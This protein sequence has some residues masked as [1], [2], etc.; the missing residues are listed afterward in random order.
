MK[1]GSFLV[2]LALAVA[3]A[4]AAEPPDAAYKQSADGVEYP[5]FDAAHRATFALG[6]NY[7]FYSAEGAEPAPPFDKEFSLGAYGAWNLVP[8]L[9]AVGS[10]A[11]GVDNQ[12][13]RT[14]L[15]V[16][17]TA[18]PAPVA[19]GLGMQYEWFGKAGDT[20]PPVPDKEFAIGARAGYP[21]N[22]WLVAVGSSFYG[23]DTKQIRSSLGLRAVL[24]SP[25][26]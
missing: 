3:P 1:K 13:V 9:S 4:F 26:I 14:A 10:V 7:E 6:G 11:Y 22:H 2:L 16:S 12:F 20:L 5:I 19:V 15:G 17:Y 24:F 21:L 23:L 8:K 18:I 25:K